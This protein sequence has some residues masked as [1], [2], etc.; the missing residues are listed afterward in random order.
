MTLPS[1]FIAHGSPFE[2]EN[3]PWQQQLHHWATKFERPGTIIVMSAHW[4][5]NGVTLGSSTTLPLVYDFGGT[6]LTKAVKPKVATKPKA[7]TN[8]RPNVKAA[9]TRKRRAA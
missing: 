6:E 4:E 5:T 8:A 1:L 3:R 7:K 2:L 9:R